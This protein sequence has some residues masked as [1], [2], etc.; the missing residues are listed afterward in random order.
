MLCYECEQDERPAVA[1]CQIC[2]KGVCREHCVERTRCIYERVESGMAA[3][4][5]LNGKRVPFMVCTQCAKAL[6]ESEIDEKII[7][8][9]ACCATA[10]RR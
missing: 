6:G 7:V 2:G 3:Q 8:R 1:V 4:L 10:P 5:R 9:P